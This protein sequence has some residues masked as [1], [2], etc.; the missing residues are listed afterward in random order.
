MLGLSKGARGGRKMS[1]LADRKEL[2]ETLALIG[3]KLDAME[4]GLGRNG[5]RADPA[6][7]RASVDELSAAVTQVLPSAATCTEN[8]A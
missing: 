6:V 1:G 7:F 2:V 8:C 3:E 5:A 4:H